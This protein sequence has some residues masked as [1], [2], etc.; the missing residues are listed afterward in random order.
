[1]E[2]IQFISLSFIFFLCL[3]LTQINLQNI[4]GGLAKK[5]KGINK[6]GEWE[7]RGYLDEYDW[8]MLWPCTKPPE[9]KEE[10]KYP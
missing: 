4:K 6:G 2:I 8:R 1:M 7:E 9:W 5:M 3:S 10:W